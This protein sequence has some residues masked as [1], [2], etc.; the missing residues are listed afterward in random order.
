M[1]INRGKRGSGKKIKKCN[2]GIDN[3]SRKDRLEEDKVY[4]CTLI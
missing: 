1:G 3:F 2:K 4:I